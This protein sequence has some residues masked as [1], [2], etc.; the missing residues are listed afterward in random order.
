MI[1]EYSNY[2]ISCN[3]TEFKEEISQVCKFNLD[4]ISVLP[5]TLRIARSIIPSNI[6]VSS[7]IDYPIGILDTKSRIS[8]IEYAAKNGAN[9]IDILIPTHSVCNRKYDKFRDDIKFNME[10]C[11]KLNISIRYILEYR[12]FTYET[13][14]K[15]AQIIES[16]GIKEILPSSGYRLDNI[17]DNILASVMINKKVPNIN[18]ICNGNVW[19]NYQIDNIIKSNLYGLRVN[20]INSLKLVFQKILK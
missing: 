1:I 7:P 4:A 11:N 16:Y 19:N 3:D 12:V 8:Q 10:L 15:I 14:Y 2:D 20:S 9:K 6:S 13:L 18:I 17:T 5:Q